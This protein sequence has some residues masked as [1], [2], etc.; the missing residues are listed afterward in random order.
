MVLMTTHGLMECCEDKQTG[1][2]YQVIMAG[3]MGVVHMHENYERLPEMCKAH[4]IIR[5]D[6]VR[7]F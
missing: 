2:I 6:C 7:F 5:N 4:Y 1:I 3:I